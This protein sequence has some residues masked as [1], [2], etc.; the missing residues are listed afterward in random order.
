VTLKL[1][2]LELARTAEFPEGSRKHGYE[3]VAPLG[4]DGHIDRAEWKRYGQ[5]CSVLRFWGEADDEHGV[6]MR[7]P[8]EHWA[9]SYT[10]GDQDDEPIQRFASHAF[11]EGEYVTIT[12]HDGVPRPFRVA[13]IKDP[14][15]LKGAH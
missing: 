11:R 1:I 10:P 14:P 2:R 3:F 12:E 7:A 8:G 13:W 6:L 9:F 15:A 4:G 5:A